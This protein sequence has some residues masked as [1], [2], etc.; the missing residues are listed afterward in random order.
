MAVSLFRVAILEDLRAEALE[1]AGT[2]SKYNKV[3]N[4]T[5]HPCHLPFLEIQVWSLS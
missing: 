3:A 4:V 2:A 5:L 1:L